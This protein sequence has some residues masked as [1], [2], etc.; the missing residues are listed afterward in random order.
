MITGKSFWNIFHFYWCSME[1]VESFHSRNSCCFFV[2]SDGSFSERAQPGPCF[3]SGTLWSLD[4][5]VNWH[6]AFILYVHFVT[7]FLMSFD[8]IMGMF[9]SQV[10]NSHLH[11]TL[12]PHWTLFWD[13]STA[14]F[15]SARTLYC[16]VEIAHAQRRADE[17]KHHIRLFL[18][19][20]NNSTQ[21]CDI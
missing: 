3:E 9:G 18:A 21:H 16:R 4:D 14:T 8:A 2:L 12:F 11:F 1:Y 13:I 20:L 10:L 15:L 6:R 7:W 5:A 19:F 17:I